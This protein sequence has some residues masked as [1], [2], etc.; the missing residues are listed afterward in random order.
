MLKERNFTA[1]LQIKRRIFCIVSILN[2]LLS[3]PLQLIFPSLAD[4]FPLPPFVNSDIYETQ[5]TSIHSRR[6]N[7]EFLLF[8]I[9]LFS[10]W[11]TIFYF[12]HPLFGRARWN[13]SVVS[14]LTIIHSW[15]QHS[16]TPPAHPTNR[17]A[18]MS[19]KRLKC[20]I[21]FL[22]F[23]SFFLSSACSRSAS[24]TP[25]VVSCGNLE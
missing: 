22:L 19:A 25:L 23:F 7:K 18:T 14:V 4:L 17:Q 20:S 21:A 16:C 2:W 15:K 8:L 3:R 13:G 11:W 6:R 12:N 9:I 24:Q 5:S 1:K 10:L